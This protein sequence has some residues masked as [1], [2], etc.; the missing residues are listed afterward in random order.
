MRPI[1]W[2]PPA[3][4]Y[5]EYAALLDIAQ[6][7]ARRFVDPSTV[8][9][10]DE[11][12]VRRGHDWAAGVLGKPWHGVGCH[13]SIE[14]ALIKAADAA[15]IHPPLPQWLVGAQAATVA[16]NGGVMVAVSFDDVTP[17]VE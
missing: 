15:D 7:E 3:P 6:Q 8:H 2:T 1:N 17:A 16:L 13:P 14:S 9:L 11:I 5:P 12:V 4:D 10:P